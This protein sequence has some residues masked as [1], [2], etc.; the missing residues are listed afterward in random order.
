MIWSRSALYLLTICFVPGH[1]L[2]YI[3]SQSTLYL[4]MICFVSDNNL[5][6]FWSRSPLYLVTICFVF[7]ND[8]LTDLYLTMILLMSC[9]CIFWFWVCLLSALLELL[10][11]ECV[12][13]H[14]ISLLYNVTPDT[15]RVHSKSRWIKRFV[16]ISF[17]VLA[18]LPKGDI[19]IAM[20]DFNAQMGSDNSTAERHGLWRLT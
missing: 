6:Y 15:I 12:V 2:L 16:A 18:T 9:V 11:S 8:L 7:D 1:D 5:L 20:G 17:C 3:W 10:P 13:M 4:L 14:E 19:I